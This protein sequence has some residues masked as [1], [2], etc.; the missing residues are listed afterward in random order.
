M[1]PYLLGLLPVCGFY[2]FPIWS[3]VLRIFALMHFHR[4]S[5]GKATAAV[6]APLVLFCGAC[7][8]LYAAAFAI[9]MGGAF[10]R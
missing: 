3:I 4:V 1:G 7:G 6:L 8:L 2:I 5:G 9:G 10:K